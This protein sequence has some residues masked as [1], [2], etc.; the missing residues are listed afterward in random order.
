[1]YGSSVGCE[2]TLLVSERTYMTSV[3]TFGYSIVLYCIVLYRTVMRFVLLFESRFMYGSSVGCEQTLLVR[4]CT[5]MTS[6]LTF[7]Y[8]IALYL[9]YCIVLCCTVLYCALYC[10]F[11]CTSSFTC[12]IGSTVWSVQTLLV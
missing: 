6:I 12:Y 8:S 5:S 2:Q 3:L 11:S 10:V 7:G 9:S 4:E 1:M